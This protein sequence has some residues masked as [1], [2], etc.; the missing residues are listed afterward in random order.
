[1]LARSHLVRFLSFDAS[2]DN[3]PPVVSSLSLLHGQPSLAAASPVSFN[4]T[5]SSN[6]T[7]VSPSLFVTSASTAAIGGVSV[8]QLSAVVYRVDVAASGLGSVVLSVAAP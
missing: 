6:V 8:H 3:S 7:G 5:F 1:M 2:A 4:V